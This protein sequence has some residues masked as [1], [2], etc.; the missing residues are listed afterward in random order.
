M[1]LR[2][3]RFSRTDIKRRGS[4]IVRAVTNLW[5]IRTLQTSS[6]KEHGVKMTAT[7]SRKQTMIIKIKE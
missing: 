7:F 2:A 6:N 5:I 3:M 4:A 1:S